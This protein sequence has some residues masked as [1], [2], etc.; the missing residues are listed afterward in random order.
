MIKNFNQ[1]LLE[2]DSTFTVVTVEELKETLDMDIIEKIVKFFN[3]E[4]DTVPQ[5]NY[6]PANIPSIVYMDENDRGIAFE[7]YEEILEILKKNAPEYTAHVERHKETDT[8]RFLPGDYETTYRFYLEP[9]KGITKLVM[10]I[11]HDQQR[12]IF[13]LK[14]DLESSYHGAVSGKRFGI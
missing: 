11:S 9:F 1:F 4:K 12:G 6:A 3:H 10:M 7:I 13:V 14:K 8:K 2:L 5:T